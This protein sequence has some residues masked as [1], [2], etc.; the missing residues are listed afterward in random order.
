MQRSGGKGVQRGG[1]EGDFIFFVKV[2]GMSGKMKEV[3]QYVIERLLPCKCIYAVRLCDSGYLGLHERLSCYSH[4]K[5]EEAFGRSYWVV[6]EDSEYQFMSY[7]DSIVLRVVREVRCYPFYW[8]GISPF[9]VHLLLKSCREAIRI[10][11]DY[12]LLLY[13]DHFVVLRSLDD[14]V[15]ENSIVVFPYDSSEINNMCWYS[16]RICEDVMVSRARIPDD[17]LNVISGY[18][19]LYSVY[20][21]AVGGEQDEN[22]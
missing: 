22:Y 20:E 11:D 21:E 19:A 2:S 3:E 10:D 4:S 6:E 1:G 17:V 9:T 18:F 5:L 13:S 7:L 8:E 15:Y 12:L 16:A 14:R